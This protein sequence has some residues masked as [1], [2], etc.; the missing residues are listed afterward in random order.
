MAYNWRLMKSVK[1]M[2]ALTKMTAIDGTSNI[3]HRTRVGMERRERMR[4]RLLESALR[5]F[6]ENG[7]GASAIQQ[8]IAAA[9]VSQGTF[10]HYFRTNE[11]LLAAVSESLNNEL[12]RVIEA[13]VGSYKDPAERIACGL[14]MYLYTT[15]A[16]PL[17]A[18]FVCAAGLHQAGP[19][20][21][22]YELLPPHISDGLNAGR[23]HDLTIEMGLDLMAGTLLA[24]VA[25]L[26]TGEVPD[27]YPEGIVVLILRGL[28]MG[29]TAAKELVGLPLAPIRL[30]PDS[31]LE[32]SNMLASSPAMA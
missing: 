4:A 12:M 11:E 3:D 29:T 32:R 31:L 9:K 5:V 2:E 16:Y 25:R 10:Y 6:T 14:R 22:I 28:G 26:S 30:A 20:N 8:V 23:F 27:D 17:F 7:V 24:A 19:N 15:R 21:L 13:E 1:K 18:R